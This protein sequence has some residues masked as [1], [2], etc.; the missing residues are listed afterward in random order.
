MHLSVIDSRK[1]PIFKKAKLRQLFPDATLTYIRAPHERAID[2]SIISKAPSTTTH[3]ILRALDRINRKDLTRLPELRY[4]GICSNGWWDY[5]FDTQALR[6]RNICVTHVPSASLNAV[7]EATLA[8]L[9]NIWRGNPEELRATPGQEIKNAHVGVLGF[10]TVGHKVAA[11]LEALGAAVFS[12]TRKTKAGF[13]LLSPRKTLEQLDALIVALPRRAGKDPMN[14]FLQRCP[15]SVAIL[16]L[17]GSEIVDPRRL[18][19]FLKQNPRAHY[20]HLTYS[21]TQLK[22]MLPSR[23]SIFYPPFFSIYTV[24]AL[25]VIAETTLSNLR[26]FLGATPTN[27]VA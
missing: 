17:S 14:N 5:Y 20:A 4:V 13:H 6:T 19:D 1:T 10:G 15:S 26:S 8:A 24:Q 22:N 9:L 23:N 2:G 16:N 11:T 12:V 27:R 18:R 25:T 7:A 3:L 21:E